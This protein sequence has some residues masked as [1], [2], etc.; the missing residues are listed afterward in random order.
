[1]ARPF[2]RG[3]GGAD[4]G[5]ASRE[6]A[7]KFRTTLTLLALGL[8]AALFFFLV[9]RPRQAKLDDEAVN[10]ATLTGVEPGKVEAITI[11]RS[12]LTITALRDGERWRITAPVEDSADDAAFNTLVRA[13]CG[14]PVDRRIETNSEGLSEFGL[15]PPAAV[16][17]LA[18][19]GGGLPFEL[20]IG[21]HN[22]TKSHCYAALGSSGTVL[23]VPASVRRYA[24]RPFSE[25]RN[26]RI[27]ELDIEEVVGVGISSPARSMTWRFDRT[28]R[29]WFT[30]ERGDTIPGDSTAVQAVV[31]ELRGLR[32]IDIPYGGAAG[33]DDYLSPASGSV[34][35]ERTPG[36]DPLTLRFGAARDGACYVERSN[37]SRIS[38]VD[39][40]ILDIFARTVNDLRY[41]RLLRY[42]DE[43]LSR[44][45]IETPERAVTL[46]L[47]GNRWTYTNPGFGDIGEDTARKLLALVRDL[48]C[49]TVIAEKIQ[50]EKDYG[51]SSPVLRLV[52]FD[53]AGGVIDELRA[54]RPAPGDRMRYVTSESAPYLASI[55]WTPLSELESL[56]GG[57][58][59]R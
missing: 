15:A 39:A 17:R 32:A 49:D 24:V 47:A 8:A 9:E 26:R 57:P 10:E 55:A 4:D 3:T 27:M 33:T 28:K 58:G 19:N 52:L 11:E 14:A 53:A 41:R 56:I 37:D 31:R 18:G 50:G 38:L 2:G 46:V 44:I 48:R 35:L 21:G 12:D 16:V 6:I 13:I 23:L 7:M 30:V 5:T 43:T 59:P 54:G 51:F 20:R 1:M 42:S 29:S 36:S 25:Y 45:S 40:A 34:V 22:V